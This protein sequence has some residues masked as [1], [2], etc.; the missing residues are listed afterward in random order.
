M[1]II[2]DLMGILK[3][4]PQLAIWVIAIIYGFKVVVV[5]SIYSV[6]RHCV[7]ALAESMNKKT[8][9]ELAKLDLE[10]A[11]LK[12]PTSISL[13]TSNNEFGCII[14][15]DAAPDLLDF[16]KAMRSNVGH[17]YVHASDIQYAYEA[18]KE[19]RARDAQV[20]TNGS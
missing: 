8:S 15:R 10:Q 11:K 17:G 3:Q 7:N 20:K 12:E 5:G 9:L 13:S 16:L 1:D 6:I 14:I 18:L 2:T 19:K 4:A